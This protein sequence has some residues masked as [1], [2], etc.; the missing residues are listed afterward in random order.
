MVARFDFTDQRPKQHRLWMLFDGKASEAC[1][2]DP[3]MD[4]DLVILA[5]S[6]AL[7]QWHTGRLE[8]GQALRANRIH[9][10]GPRDLAS[11]L[12]TWNKRSVWSA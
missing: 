2:T 11:A 6:T 12:P 1:L 5:E 8:W 3:G 7:A 4:E 9:V 10:P